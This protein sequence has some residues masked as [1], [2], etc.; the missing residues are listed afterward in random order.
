VD[1]P[2][3]LN[4]AELPIHG[5]IAASVKAGIPTR[6]EA[7]AHLSAVTFGEEGARGPG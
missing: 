7:G 6:S 4:R 5:S 2:A 3:P 1:S